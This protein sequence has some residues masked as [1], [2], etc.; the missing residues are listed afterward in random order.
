MYPENYL[1]INDA[2]SL[3]DD[4]RS[5]EDVRYV[6]YSALREAIVFAWPRS[7]RYRLKNECSLRLEKLSRAK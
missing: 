4:C 2:V 3:L 6:F 7:W 5:V 1:H